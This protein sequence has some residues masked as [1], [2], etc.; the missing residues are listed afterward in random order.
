MAQELQRDF[1]L[2]VVQVHLGE[3]SGRPAVDIRLVVNVDGHQEIVA[4]QRHEMVDFGFVGTGGREPPDLGV[5]LQVSE[6]IADWVFEELDPNE[7]LWLHLVKPYGRFGAVPWERDVQPLIHIPFLRLPDRLPERVRASSTFDV[8]LCA[9]APAE[10]G[11]STAA[12]MGPDVASALADG[13]GDRLRLHVFADLEAHGLLQAELADLPI[14]EIHVHE[15]DPDID[16]ADTA[17][18]GLRGQNTWLRW[19]RRAMKG[20]TLDA[21]HFITHGG[22][23]GYD[24]AILTTSSPTSTDRRYPQ[25]VQ[26][27]EL[28]TFLTQVGALNAGFT[29]PVDNYSDFG[30]RRVVDELGSLRPGPVVLHDPTLDPGMDI[31]R[32]GYSFLSSPEPARP[33]AHPSL[34]LFAQP[35]QIADINLDEAPPTIVFEALASSSAVNEHFTR[36]DTPVWLSAAERYIDQH[37]ADLIRFRQ[38]QGDRSQTRSQVAYYEGVESALRKIRIVV[39]KHA[40]K[41]L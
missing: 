29:R 13:I 21:V 37:E 28:R 5:P 14:R 39:D 24:G 12:L 15:P 2:P 34:M 11:P 23:L 6:W 19:I 27:G 33:P 35:R 22:A 7:V 1:S 4:N 25:T 31:L 32:G 10:E 8:A 36:D 40:E 3:L 41:G 17:P 18:P 38:S 9:T 20:R 16:A 26:S 30:L